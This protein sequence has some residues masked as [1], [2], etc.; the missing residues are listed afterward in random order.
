M[1]F[2]GL[3]IPGNPPPSFS[4]MRVG[5]GL[6]LESLKPSEAKGAL[7]GL[8]WTPAGKGPGCVLQEAAPLVSAAGSRHSEKTCRREQ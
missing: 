1:T 7:P 8:P 4:H 3:P 2:L 5:W 6:W